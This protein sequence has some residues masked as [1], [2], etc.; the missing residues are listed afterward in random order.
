MTSTVAAS[1]DARLERTRPSL[2][3]GRGSRRRDSHCPTRRRSAVTRTAPTVSVNRHGVARLRPAAA[4]RARRRVS[5]SPGGD[6]APRASGRRRR[7]T[8]G[9]RVRRHDRRSSPSRC[10]T[11]SSVIDLAARDGAGPRA[12]Y[13]RAAPSPSPPRRRAAAPP[14]HEDEAH[15][16]AGARRS[17]P[18]RA[19]EP[20]APPPR[21]SAA[22][23][24]AT[25]T[26]PPS[27]PRYGIARSPRRG[28][29]R[30]RRRRAPRARHQRRGSSDHDGERR[31]R[32][33]PII[34]V[35]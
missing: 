21:S 8:S 5:G 26:S 3:A 13:G 4:P 35:A 6:V 11:S 10:S 2:A 12:A 24:T 28:E 27:A 29:H 14:T 17:A 31:A 1:R 7:P 19:C 16:R 9:R 34:A 18:A 30:R 33:V 23:S 15:R 22:R 32:T 20:C 25:A